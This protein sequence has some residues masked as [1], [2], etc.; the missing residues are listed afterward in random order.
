MSHVH[1]NIEF[2]VTITFSLDAADVP[3]SVTVEGVEGMPPSVYRV[4]A[5]EALDTH[6]GTTVAH[7]GY[8]V[9]RAPYVDGITFD[10]YK[11]WQRIRADREG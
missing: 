6:Y 11:T 10:V 5:Q 8:E 7:H 3:S 9:G 1:Y 4:I 2:N